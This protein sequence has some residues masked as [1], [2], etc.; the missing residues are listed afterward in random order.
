MHECYRDKPAS[1][2]RCWSNPDSFPLGQRGAWDAPKAGGAIIREKVGR[3]RKR[4][5]K[6]NI[7]S[8]IPTQLM[9]LAND[10]GFGPIKLSEA[11]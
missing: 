11:A 5:K 8:Q 2:Q 6:T 10:L 3:N 9:F 4:R 1:V 7:H